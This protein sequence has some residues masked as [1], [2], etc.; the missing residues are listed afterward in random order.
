M[1]AVRIKV[2]PRDDRWEPLI[3]LRGGLTAEEAL[4]LITMG[5]PG[6]TTLW[7]WSSVSC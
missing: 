7:A 3:P 6:Q 2:N 5:C 1:K 4:C